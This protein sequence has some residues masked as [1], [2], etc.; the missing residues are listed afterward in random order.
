MAPASGALLDVRGLEV[1][2]DTEE[3]T[4]SAVDGVTFQ[5]A[6]GEVL[7]V[8]GESG[9]GKSVTALTLL[10]LSRSPNARFAGS[11][12]F[13]D[14]DL[15]T[16]SEE[17]LRRIR[18]AEIAMIFQDPLTSLNPVMRIGAQ[19]AEQ[20]QAHEEVAGTAARER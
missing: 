7:A 19:I 18:G 15:V 4:V 6:A 1:G 14:V 16:A 5:L 3:G 8:V 13:G 12:W 10:G 2:F 20:I 9:S 11:A 17:E